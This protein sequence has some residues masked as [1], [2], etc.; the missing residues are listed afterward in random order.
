MKLLAVILAAA[1]LT[2]C[3]ESEEQKKR[4]KARG[5]NKERPTKDESKDVSFQGFVGRLRVAVQRRDTAML[6]TMMSPDFGYRWDSGP[7]GE[8]P[9]DFWQKHNLW[10]ELATLLGERWVPY[11]G[12]M[13]VPPTM[14]SNPDFNGYRAGLKQYNG[15]W[16]F[17]YFVPAPPTE[18][19]NELPPTNTPSAPSPASAPLPPIP[20]VPPPQ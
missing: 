14:A 8:T 17:A 18:A 7:P 11:D 12:Y 13:V 4:D 16:R 19:N 9:F 5:T 6:E 10:G 3:F 2:G 1:V 20:S 15:A